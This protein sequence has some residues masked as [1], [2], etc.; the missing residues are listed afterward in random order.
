MPHRKFGNIPSGTP[1]G[2]ASVF[3]AQQMSAKYSALVPATAPR[4][5]VVMQAKTENLDAVKTKEVVVPL[6]DNA[7]S[8]EMLDEFLSKS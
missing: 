1:A 2:L 3:G 8:S 5:R 6:P 4:A 7:K